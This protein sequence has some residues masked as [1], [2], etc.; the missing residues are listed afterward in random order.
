MM[1]RPPPRVGEQDAQTVIRDMERQVQTLQDSIGWTKN[2][3]T[4]IEQVRKVGQLRYRN[5]TPINP[6]TRWCDIALVFPDK[7]Q[8]DP[9]IGAFTIAC[10]YTQEQLHELLD[11]PEGTVDSM[12]IATSQQWLKVYQTRPFDVWTVE[13]NTLWQ[14]DTRQ[15]Q[16]WLNRRVREWVQY[17]FGFSPACVYHRPEGFQVER[18]GQGMF[19]QYKAKSVTGPAGGNAGAP[20]R[21]RP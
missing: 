8:E 15:T 2:V 9:D 16:V 7:G 20:A 1:H 11:D 21:T 18:L 5:T 19:D 17:W 10:S 4:R 12:R 14:G 13:E 3:V 6:E